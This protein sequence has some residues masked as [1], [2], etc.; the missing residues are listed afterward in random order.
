MLFRYFEYLDIFVGPKKFFKAPN[1]PSLRNFQK[2]FLESKNLE[3][4]SQNNLKQTKKIFKVKSEK[5]SPN[6]SGN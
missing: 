2:K 3:N 4:N 6:H 1:R 5:F